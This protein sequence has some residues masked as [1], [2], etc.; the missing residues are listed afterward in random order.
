MALLLGVLFAS[1]YTRF[2]ALPMI[3]DF[4]AP[5]ILLVPI[6]FVFNSNISR[7]VANSDGTQFSFSGAR[8]NIP[9]VMVVFDE[10]PLLSLLDETANIDS[11]RYPNFATL[12]SESHWFRN[13]RSLSGSTTI[14]IPA[15]VSGETKPDALPIAVDYPR[16]LFTLLNASHQLNVTEQVTSLCPQSVCDSTAIGTPQALQQRLEGFFTDLAVVYLH[17]LLPEDLTASLPTISQSWGNFVNRGVSETGP[18]TETDNSES[19]DEKYAS[20]L[21]GIVASEKP[22]LN[23]HHT[24]LP[25]VAWE[26]LPSGK[27]YSI[28]GSDVP[29][30]NFV[31]EIW[32]DDPALVEQGYQRHLLQVGF[33]DKLL[34]DLIAKLKSEN[35]YDESLI[36][37]VSDHGVNFWP[38]ESRR[39]LFDPRFTLDTLG[40]TLLI[41]QPRQSVG[42]V[43]DGEV[44]SLDILPTIANSLGIQTDDQFQGRDL[45]GSDAQSTTS[46]DNP[47][48]NYASLQR[49]LKLFGSG[50]L[51]T[52]YGL[53]D[54]SQLLNLR[55]SD[56]D[57]EVSNSLTYTIDQQSNLSDVSLSDLM[58]PARVTGELMGALI[59]ETDMDLAVM[60]NRKLIA[61]S[62]P[63]FSG[64]EFRFSIMLPENEIEN[65][66]NEF[67]LFRIHAEAN[68]TFRLEQVRN[69]R[70]DFYRYTTEGNLESLSSVDNESS[71]IAL[72]PGRVRGFVDSI[73]LKQGF[74]EII[75]WAANIQNDE[76]AEF[77]IIDINGQLVYLGTPVLQRSDVATAFDAPSIEESGYLL[78]VRATRFADLE[79][80]SVK[81]IGVSGNEASL[82]ESNFDISER[83]EELARSQ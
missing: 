17:V 37:I 49:K 53:G 71:E 31:N 18:S 6:L 22:S 62:K 80:L 13:A 24:L 39:D 30:L 12:A 16:N 77:L 38:G 33:V 70:G 68:E 4:L 50:E 26:Y 55:K 1:M 34:G 54:F 27:F 42:I 59:D 21:N 66:F 11:V 63:Y 64:S 25:H 69:L 28:Y 19:R 47:Y 9:V 46:A 20:F 2:E 35:L 5:A 10:L 57:L 75:G 3:C 76:P 82:L 23:F 48:L 65:G 79:P 78:D 58:I 67:E 56:F 43:H 45:F 32:G 74:L 41:K 72:I 61:V 15:I 81:V 29:G 44:S 14:A 7:V 51:S 73:S 8:N 60:L 40:I 83:I 36:V 52:L